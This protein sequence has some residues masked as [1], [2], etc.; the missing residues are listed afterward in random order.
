[1][2]LCKLLK[3]NSDYVIGILALALL[4]YAFLNYS[5]IKHS[6]L[7]GVD[8]SL[9]PASY[10]DNKP[11]ADVPGAGTAKHAATVS[12]MGSSVNQMMHLKKD[13]VD[14][15]ELLPM[16]NNNEF[17]KLNPSGSGNLSGVNMLTA[18]N[19]AFDMLSSTSSTLRN[20]NLQ[21]RSEPPNPQGSVGPW[22]QT[23]IT[24]DTSRRPLEIGGSN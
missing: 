20:A 24:P 4:A 3:S 13:S 2:D 6:P 21:L 10:P 8:K 16:D 18:G 17:A 11:S 23:T 15:R 1:M 22:N 5:K 14:P 12:D 7:M 19:H 9:S